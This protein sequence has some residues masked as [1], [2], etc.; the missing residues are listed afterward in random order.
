MSN[1]IKINTGGGNFNGIGNITGGN[2]HIINNHATPTQPQ[3]TSRTTA[4][5]RYQQLMLNIAETYTL[6]G[7]S[8][9]QRITATDPNE[10]TRLASYITEAK[11]NLNKYQEEAASLKN[12]FGFSD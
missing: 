1:D 6:I 7:D 2:N 4:Q 11:Q 5:Q 3:I 9:K 8:E 10:R 12:Q